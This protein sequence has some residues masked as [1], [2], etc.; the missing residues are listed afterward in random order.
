VSDLLFPTVRPDHGG[1]PDD[2]KLTGLDDFG[3]SDQVFDWMADRLADGP[4][5]LVVWGVYYSASVSSP[6][7]H[8]EIRDRVK[9]SRSIGYRPL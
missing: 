8:C 9:I 7:W 3:P 4:T 1:T 2:R 6:R 5:R